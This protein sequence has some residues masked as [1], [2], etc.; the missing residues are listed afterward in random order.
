MA[1]LTRKSASGGAAD[2]MPAVK[3]LPVLQEAVQGC[4]VR[5]LGAMRYRALAAPELARR[6]FA[7]G[8]TAEALAAAPMLVFDRKDR[9]QHRFL[10]AAT[11][12]DLDP[13]THHLPS[14]PGFSEAV[15]RGLGWALIPE[16]LARPDLAAGVCVDL[17]PDRELDLRDAEAALDRL[18]VNTG[19][20]LEVL[21]RMAGLAL[22]RDRETRH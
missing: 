2:F 1:A 17:A 16:P 5:R 15:R 19:R 18:E 6:W 22:N 14:V 12:L 4:R 7:D 21:R 13:P 9:V 20:A 3:T 10:R 8:L 11:G